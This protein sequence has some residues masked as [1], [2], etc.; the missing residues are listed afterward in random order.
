M[1]ISLLAI[2]LLSSTAWGQTFEALNVGV[3]STAW[4]NAV[5]LNSPSINRDPDTEFMIA[6]IGGDAGGYTVNVAADWNTSESFTKVAETTSSG[7][8][9]DV[10]VS[11]WCLK[12]PTDTTAT[13][14]ASISPSGS[15]DSGFVMVWEWSGMADDTCANVWSEVTETVNNTASSTNVLASGGTSGELGMVACSFAGADGD[16]M[17]NNSSLV[18]ETG[19]EGD[20]GGGAGTPADQSYYAVHGTLAFGTTVTFSASDENACFTMEGLIASASSNVNLLS[21]KLGQKLK[22][23]IQ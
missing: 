15:T 8:S 21:G 17:S 10:W 3:D 22:G 11:A 1:R 6:I 23:K 13:V 5:P 4:S 16:P 18:E 14:T 20:T 12:D 2:L 19:S 9:G 7:S